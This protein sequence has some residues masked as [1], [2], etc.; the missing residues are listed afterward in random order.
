MRGQ[1]HQG[2]GRHK[3]KLSAE[4]VF[5][6]IPE[7]AKLPQP[8]HLMA[9]LESSKISPASRLLDARGNYLKPL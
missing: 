5:W 1:A 4:V 6:V 9:H 2:T 8:C 7:E 3:T